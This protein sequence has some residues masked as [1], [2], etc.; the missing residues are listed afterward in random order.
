MTLADRLADAHQRSVA[1]Y[2]ERQQVEAQ[3]Q[4]CQLRAQQ[5]DL[6]LVALDGEIAILTTLQAAPSARLRVAGDDGN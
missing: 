4:Q 1:L 5:I 6:A 3:R 2:L